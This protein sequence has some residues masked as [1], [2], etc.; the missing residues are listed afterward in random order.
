MSDTHPL[1]AACSRT[2]KELIL[3]TLAAAGNNYQE[4][5]AKLNIGL[6]SLYRKIKEH[7]IRQ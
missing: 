2:E 4:A 6:S 7:G 1:K 3:Q 5:A